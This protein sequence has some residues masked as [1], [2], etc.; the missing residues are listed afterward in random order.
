MTMDDPMDDDATQP[1]RSPRKKPV[2]SPYRRVVDPH[3]AGLLGVGV[4]IGVAIGAG[5]AM[6]FAPQSGEATRD[7]LRRRIRRVR[8]NTHVWKRLGK[9]LKRAGSLKRKEIELARKKA[10][11]ER[12]RRNAEAGKV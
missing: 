1:P 10:E 2:G 8:G 3:S 6:L 4:I 5:V 12:E 11:L 7:M 9:E